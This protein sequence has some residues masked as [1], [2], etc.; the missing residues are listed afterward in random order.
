M[1]PYE[2]GSRDVVRAHWRVSLLLRRFFVR[3]RRQ[4]FSPSNRRRTISSTSSDGSRRREKRDEE[5]KGALHHATMRDWYTTGFRQG[6]C[7]VRGSLTRFVGRRS[8]T[9]FLGSF[10]TSKNYEDDG[11]HCRHPWVFGVQ[12]EIERLTK[13][14][15][16]QDLTVKVHVLEKLCFD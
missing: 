9:P 2:T 5:A 13:R 11:L 4:S 10:F 15:Q 6:V 12:E 1:I 7:V 14:E 16:V 3:R 8:T